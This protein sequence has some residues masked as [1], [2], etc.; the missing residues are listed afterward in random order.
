MPYL[1]RGFCSGHHSRWRKQGEDPIDMTKPIRLRNKNQER[2][3]KL[4]KNG[5]L[6]YTG[7]PHAKKFE[8]VVIAEKALGRPLPKNAVIHH[9]NEIRS[10]N[11]SGNLVICQDQAYHMLLHLRAK[12]VKAGYPPYYRCCSFCMKYDGPANLVIDERGEVYHA[13]CCPTKGTGKKRIISAEDVK[14]SCPDS[15]EQRRTE[16]LARGLTPGQLSGLVKGWSYERTPEIKLNASGQG[17]PTAKLTN[18]IVLDIRQRYADKGMSQRAIGALYGITQANV[19]E[20]VNRKT[21]KHI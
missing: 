14:K 1:A 19:S 10:D 6:I 20:I 8:H 2:P 13:L 9:V 4:D 17:N 18:E 7:G 5:Y 16:L 15:Q 21:W 12:A 3:P 11:S